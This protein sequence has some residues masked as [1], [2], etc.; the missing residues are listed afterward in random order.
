VL[1]LKSDYT[2]TLH[3]IEIEEI[4]NKRVK[5]DVYAVLAALGLEKYVNKEEN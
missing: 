4:P 1:E 2:N 3:I 5:W